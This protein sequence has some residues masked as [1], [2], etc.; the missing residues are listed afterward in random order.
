MLWRP[1]QW[2]MLLWWLESCKAAGVDGIWP[3]MLKVLDT[4]EVVWLTFFFWRSGAMILD[5][6]NFLFLNKGDQ[7]LWST[8]R[9]T[10]LHLL[11]EGYRKGG[12]D[13]GGTMWVPPR[14]W[15]IGWVLDSNKVVSRLHSVVVFNT[16]SLRGVSYE[17]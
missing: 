15:N 12:S 3:E 7:R 5:W 9:I 4:L 8:Y 13:S 14:L 16:H 10:P 1:S 11:G 17:D 2:L 6:H